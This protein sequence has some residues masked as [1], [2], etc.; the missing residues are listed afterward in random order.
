MNNVHDMDDNKVNDFNLHK[1]I[2]MLNSDQ[3]RI[4]T[5]SLS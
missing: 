4:F 1:H 5:N 3:L 2:E